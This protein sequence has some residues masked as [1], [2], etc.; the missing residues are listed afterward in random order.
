MKYIP[1][2]VKI[3]F[4]FAVAAIMILS[5]CN[6]EPEQ[7]QG[8]VVTPPSGISLG[9]TITATTDNSFYLALI[10]RAGLLSTINN[11]ATSYTMFVPGNTAMKIFVNIA[12][13]G[14]IPIGAPD[15]VFLD[16][17][18]STLPVATANAIVSYNILPQ[19]IR[20]TDI[21]AT[22][23]NLQYP[24]IFNPAPAIS[25]LLRL[26]TFPSTIN[27]NW[28]NNIPLTTVDITASNGVIHNSAFLVT[29]PS[30]YLW[31]RISTDTDLT[32]LNAA[33]IR[34]DS[35][36]AAPGFLQGVLLNI[37]ANLTIFAP[38]DS[39]FKA[40]LDTSIRK[41]LWSLL[42]QPATLIDSLTAA[43]TATFLAS[44]PAV[45]SN[46]ALYSVL[47]AQTVQ[48]IVLYHILGSRAFTNNF[49][50]T[51]AA[52]PT[53]LTSAIPTHPEV[54]LSATFTGPSV[55]GATIQGAYSATAANVIIS[56][57]PLLPEPFGTS[58]QHYLNGVLHKI[59][60]VLLPQ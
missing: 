33:I 45:F 4:L 9:A 31:N 42:P 13:G 2:I 25:D 38:T 19:V 11:T 20:I 16:F 30:R 51:P 10:T 17:I 56:A 32:Y 35:G 8:T 47:T 40:I 5:S 53:L 39:S 29:P 14:Q 21:P 36:T 12:S 55:S 23:P 37:G 41:A 43:G 27:G 26:T 44:S 60:Q 48:G 34:A 50:T 6:K 52:F 54:T 24:S 57:N 1:K 7:I 18:S 46:P 49:P 58:D 22:F 15:A 3:S 28:V 59:D